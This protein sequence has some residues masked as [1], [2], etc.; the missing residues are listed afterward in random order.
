MF[1]VPI[2]IWNG[3]PGLSVGLYI[4]KG[5]IPAGLGNIVGGGFFCATTLW[6]LHL[7]GQP[8]CPVDGA[9]YEPVIVHTT[10]TD[11]NADGMRFR[12]K[13]STKDEE[14]GEVSDNK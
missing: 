1:L 10:G 7:E 3:A 14:S 12:H 8:P 5:I 2:G 13:S 11:P 9:F 6:Y 4:W